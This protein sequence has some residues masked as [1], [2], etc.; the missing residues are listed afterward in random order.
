MM[1]TCKAGVCW[2]WSGGGEG[3]PATVTE[4][5]RSC[6]HSHSNEMWYIF[7]KK[8]SQ[9]FFKLSLTP[10]HFHTLIKVWCQIQITYIYKLQQELLQWWCASIY[11]VRWHPL[12]LI[13]EYLCLSI[14]LFLFIG[15]HEFLQSF[16]WSVGPFS[17]FSFGPLIHWLNVKCQMSYVIFQMSKIKCQTSN[18]KGQ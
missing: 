12:L 14:M 8:G 3:Q 4:M 5:S 15:S 9:V 10:S 6:K 2:E 18:A 11:P 1:S 7:S 17:I 16:S 13:F